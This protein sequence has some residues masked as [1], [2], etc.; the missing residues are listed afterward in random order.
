MIDDINDNERRRMYYGIVFDFL[1]LLKEAVVLALCTR[2]FR[3]NVQ[4]A[5]WRHS[6]FFGYFA[7]FAPGINGL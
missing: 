4:S 1:A 3:D 5:F 6:D 7:A 2:I